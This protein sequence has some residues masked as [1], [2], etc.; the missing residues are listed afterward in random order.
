[1]VTLQVLCKVILFFLG[2][3]V[4][5]DSLQSY[6]QMM[7]FPGSENWFVALKAML[8]WVNHFPSLHLNFL[9]CE[10]ARLAPEVSSGEALMEA[11]ISSL[12]KLRAWTEPK[13]SAPWAGWSGNESTGVPPWLWGSADVTH[14]LHCTSLKGPVR[15]VVVI[16]RPSVRQIL[17][18]YSHQ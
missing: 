9:T 15:G 10:T 6:E 3:P 11:A 2:F 14:S 4:M 8:P 17:T 13:N 16:R 12:L 5:A 18:L 7:A 1:M